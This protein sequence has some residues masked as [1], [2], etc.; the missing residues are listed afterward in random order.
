MIGLP[1]PLPPHQ[2]VAMIGLPPTSSTKSG[3]CDDEVFFARG[4]GDE[5]VFATSGRCDDWIASTISTTSGGCDDWIASTTG[6]CD[7]WLSPHQ[8]GALVGFLPRIREV[9]WLHYFCHTRG[10]H[11]CHIRAQ[12]AACRCNLVN[13]VCMCLCIPVGYRMLWFCARLSGT[14]K[15]RIGCFCV[16]ACVFVSVF[17]CVFLRVFLCVCACLCALFF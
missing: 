1:S 9:R 2:G 6:R 4:C 8:G 16:F 12:D 10:V 5:V 13:D 17:V 15:H 14:R 11:F 3:R 7:D